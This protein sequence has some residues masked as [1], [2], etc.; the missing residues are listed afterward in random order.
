MNVRSGA[1]R[2]TAGGLV[3]RV[4]GHQ[5]DVAVLSE[6]R[7]NAAGA[8]L[9]M[10]LREG[11]LHE[12][13]ATEGHAGNGVLVAARERFAGLRNPFGLMED[14]YPN[15][16]IEARF[17]RLRLFGVY[18]PG[19]DRK[20]PHLRCLIATA[21]RYE[22][23][24]VAAMAIG[25]FNSGRN[26]TDIELNLGRQRLADEFSTADLYA[27][28]EGEWTEAWLHLHPGL[29]EFSWYPFRKAAPPQRRNGWRIDKAFVS[30]ALLPHVCRAEYDHGFR[31]EGLT[32]HSGLVVDV[33]LT[34]RLRPLRRPQGPRAATNPRSL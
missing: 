12:Q 2:S 22:E 23:R 30:G 11:G 3:E 10:A 18:L 24:G 29:R 1:S 14:E 8:A 34:R 33:D 21:R 20:R 32:D 9:R 31:L 16:V 4:L 28:L 7:D 15:A 25:D 5:P 17:E 13:C 27:E 6:F 19:Q 26:A